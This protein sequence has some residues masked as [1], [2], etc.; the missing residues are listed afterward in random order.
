[1]EI[2]KF[3]GSELQNPVP[4]DKKIGVGDY[5]GDKYPHAKTKNDRPIGGVAAYRGF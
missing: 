3:G 4:I 1:M 2:A 5:V